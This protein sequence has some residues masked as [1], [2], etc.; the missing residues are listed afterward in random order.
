MSGLRSWMRLEPVSKHRVAGRP[1]PGFGTDMANGLRRDS[2]ES[3]LRWLLAR[4]LAF[5]EFIGSDTASPV[6]TELD[7]KVSSLTRMR[8]SSAGRSHRPAFGWWATGD[9]CGGGTR[10]SQW[11]GRGPAA[12]RR[13]TCGVALPQAAEASARTRRLGILP[14]R[15]LARYPFPAPPR[16]RQRVPRC[17]PGGRAHP[18]LCRASS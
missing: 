1:Y 3:T 2:R 18:S 15:S 12:A 4:Q 17:A 11:R 6:I 16:D 7:Y 5:G 8:G 10:A 13:S 14:G 9:T